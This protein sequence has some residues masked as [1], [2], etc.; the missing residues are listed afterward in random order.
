MSTFN[1]Q[2]QCCVVGGTVSTDN[3][4]ICEGVAMRHASA[5]VRISDLPN[6]NKIDLPVM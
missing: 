2:L 1:L 5:S 4:N 6:V 3:D